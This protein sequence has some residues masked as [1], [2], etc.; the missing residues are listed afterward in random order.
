M[1]RRTFG[2]GH[3]VSRFRCSRAWIFAGSFAITLS[4]LKVDYLS[5]ISECVCRRQF[6]DMHFIECTNEMKNKNRGKKRRKKTASH[7]SLW[8]E[9]EQKYSP[10][11]ATDTLELKYFPSIIIV[12]CRTDK[13]YSLTLKI[14]LSPWNFRHW[15]QASACRRLFFSIDS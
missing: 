14:S 7:S 15:L 4:V 5:R 11:F 13:L 9:W 1:W 10:I 8:W 3:L 6:C 2:L 12:W